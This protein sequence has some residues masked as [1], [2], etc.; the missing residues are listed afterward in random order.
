MFCFQIFCAKEFSA[1]CPLHTVELNQMR[2]MFSS[3]F[4]SFSLK[5]SVLAILSWKSWGNCNCGNCPGG[6]C[7][8]GNFLGGSVQEVI[9]LFPYWRTKNVYLKRSYFCLSLQ[10]FQQSV[11]Q[12]Q[13]FSVLILCNVCGVQPGLSKLFTLPWSLWVLPSLIRKPCSYSPVSV[14]VFSCAFFHVC[15]FGSCRHVVYCWEYKAEFITQCLYWM[16]S[17]H[18][19]WSKV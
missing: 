14:I 17:E 11:C 6:N 10:S 19:E 4:R 8:V 9:V 12:S 16:F 13:W 1:N 2:K 18:G 15:C 3:I 5:N 7:P